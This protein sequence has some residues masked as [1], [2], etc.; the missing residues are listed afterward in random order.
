M[1]PALIA[2]G[3]GAA[4]SVG[5]AILS[6]K[7]ANKAANTAAN[8]QTQ[9]AGQNNALT[10]EV[11]DRNTANMNPFM[12]S[13]QRAGS[14]L[15]GLLYGTTAPTL[16]PPAT[17]Y[18][19]GGAIYSPMH[20]VSDAGSW[21][22]MPDSF[23]QPGQTGAPPP[24]ISTMPS[25]FGTGQSAFDQFRGGTNYQFR[26]TE[27]LRALNQGYAA[28]G[29][30]ESGAAM[31]GITNF[32]QDMASNELGNYMNLLQGQQNLGMGAASAL[33]GVGQNMVGMTTQNNQNAADAVSNAAL[34]RG[35]ASQQMY[36]GVA[37]AL[38]NFAS[39]YKKW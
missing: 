14:A 36:G 7:S 9:V 25:A 34:L 23:G 28:R 16:P 39:S 18:M 21:R 29:M 31:K 38:G 15:D 4:A 3:I 8:A 22:D 10:R 32:G 5:G 35:Q 11:Y 2:A 17:P 27:G 33:S 6:N 20:A 30:L 13:G 19:E 24:Y 26:L 12:Q 1:P 37:S